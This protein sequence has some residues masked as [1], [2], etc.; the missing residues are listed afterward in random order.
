MFSSWLDQAGHR[1]GQSDESGEV[2]M[3]KRGWTTQVMGN[4]VIFQ[5]PILD[6]LQP[7]KFI[8][9]TWLKFQTTLELT[10]GSKC[11]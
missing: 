5:V 11:S 1:T 4:L 8:A 7:W 2:T 9:I 10:L 6:A 3:T